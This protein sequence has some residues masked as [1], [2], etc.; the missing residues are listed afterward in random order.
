LNEKKVYFI[1]FLYPENSEHV[2]IDNK[3]QILAPTISKTSASVPI[4]LNSQNKSVVTPKPLSICSVPRARK[5]IKPVKQSMVSLE[6]ETFDFGAMQWVKIF[7][8]I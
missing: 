1:R 3:P 6:L 8:R 4:N 7:L 2:I 5:L